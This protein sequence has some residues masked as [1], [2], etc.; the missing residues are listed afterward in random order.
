MVKIVKHLCPD[1]QSAKT[2]N[3]AV[4]NTN[5]YI[6]TFYSVWTVKPFSVRQNKLINGHSGNSVLYKQ[7]QIKGTK[8]WL[9]WI[10][11]RYQ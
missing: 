7:K 6:E 4:N 10:N 8:T 9:K 5:E 1:C 11:I 2:R 3:I